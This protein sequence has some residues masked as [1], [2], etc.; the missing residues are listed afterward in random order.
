MR[1]T[2]GKAL[3]SACLTRVPMRYAHAIRPCDT[4]MKYANEIRSCGMDMRD[5]HAG[6]TCGMHMRQGYAC[7]PSLHIPSDYLPASGSIPAEARTRFARLLS[8]SFLTPYLQCRSAGGQSPRQISW[9]SDPKADQLVV[10]PGR[11]SAAP[12]HPTAGTLSSRA[13]PPPGSSWGWT[14]GGVQGGV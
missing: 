10:C 9:W 11:I 5:G 3:L 1:R 8:A 14:V 13:F 4:L 2:Q 7:D 12:N 6:C